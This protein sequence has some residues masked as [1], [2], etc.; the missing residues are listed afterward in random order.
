MLKKVIVIYDKSDNLNKIEYGFNFIFNLPICRFETKISYTDNFTEDTKN[1]DVLINYSETEIINA[2]S[3]KKNRIV[4]FVKSFN[5]LLKIKSQVYSYKNQV[6]YGIASSI[7][8]RAINYKVG[9]T[10]TLDIIETIFFHLSRIE[11]FYCPDSFKDSHGRMK[12]ENQFLVRNKIERIPVLDA[13]CFAFLE[14]LNFQTEIKSKKIMTHDIDVLLKYPN[15]YKYIRGAARIL[16]RNKKNKGTLLKFTKHYLATLRGENDPFNTFSWFLNNNKFDEKLIFFMS[17]GLT[18]YDNL[19]EISEIKSKNIYSQAIE[20]GYQLG[21]HPSYSAFNDINQ[22]KKEIEIIETTLK[23]K[24]NSSRQHILH[25]DVQETP[26]ILSDLE[27]ERDFTLGYQDRIGF[28]AGTGFNFNL[29]NLE[30]NV[31]LNIIETPLIIMDGCLLI[32]ADYN[33]IKAKDIYNDFIISNIKNTQITYN[34]HNSIFDPVLLD[35]DEL[36]KFYLSL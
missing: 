23:I 15:L 21:L 24:I 26:K 17:G 16:F 36:K 30:K 32:E 6:L 28:R 13:I 18:K 20:C 31:M 25:Y 14:V 3:I 8:N 11:E 1:Y 19:Y 35:D 10:I 22:F 2:I 27:I 9:N 34:F 7:E 5:D 12:S 33:V 4:D 29:W